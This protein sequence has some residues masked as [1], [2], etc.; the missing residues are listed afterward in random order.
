MTEISVSSRAYCKMIFHA[1]KYPHLAVNGLL[2][3]SKSSS[4]RSKLEIID[5]VPLFHQ[6]LHVSPMA[7]IALIQVESKAAKEGLQIIGYYAA[8]EN[9]YDNTIEKAP[10]CKIADKIAENVS[11]ACFVVIDNR[12]V[13]TNMLYPA[14]KMWQQIDS[15]WT[16][17]KYSLDDSKNTLEAV[18]LLLQRGAMKEL[19]DFDNYLDNTTNDWFNLHLNR[20]LSKILSMH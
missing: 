9:F 10:G 6:C 2:L 13:C 11:N 18:S 14:L 17:S 4:D 12:S 16:K 19:N 20:D 3:A 7:E 8:A 1:A 15:K 5:A